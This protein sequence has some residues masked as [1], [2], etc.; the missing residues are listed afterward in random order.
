MDLIFG[1][2]KNRQQCGSEIVVSGFKVKCPFSTSI[3]V[4][5]PTGLHYFDGNLDVS[6]SSLRVTIPICKNH[7]RQLTIAFQKLSEKTA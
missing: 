1:E 2:T 5:I 7:E 3:I 6:E 4:T